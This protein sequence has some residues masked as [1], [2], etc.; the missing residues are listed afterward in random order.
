[1]AIYT[2]DTFKQEVLRYVHPR[3]HAF[4]DDEDDQ[5]QRINERLYKFCSL[6][7]CF[8]DD[9]II[10]SAQNGTALYSLEKTSGSYGFS[11]TVISID[12]FWL[13]GA[14]LEAKTLQDLRDLGKYQD[15]TGQP[16][17]YVLVPYGEYGQIRLYP[18][19][20]ADYTDGAVS[21][22]VNHPYLSDSADPIVLPLDFIAVA[23]VYCAVGF[24]F[25][26]A[27][28]GS[29]VDA[30]RPINES[31]ADQMQDLIEKA[32]Y[33]VRGSMVRGLTFKGTKHPDTIG[34]Y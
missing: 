1:M 10:F 32:Q 11:K 16:G 23:A 12:E 14:K 4:S 24:L 7:K 5:F 21:G 27:A 28:S 20:S 3:G 13:G 9:A 34:L 25:P 18:E 8:Y 22:F 33:D 2:L 30:M 26:G 6:T 17:A 29:D 31:A 15:H 19:P